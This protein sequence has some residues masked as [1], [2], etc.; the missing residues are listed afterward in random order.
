MLALL[1]ALLPLPGLAGDAAP[2]PAL[3]VR[4]NAVTVSGISSG[5]Y[6]A[7]QYHFAHSASVA[8]VGVLAAGPYDCAAGSIWA[9]LTRCMEPRFWSPLPD[10]ETLNRRAERSARDGLI[11]SLAGLD[12]DRAWI[13]SGGQDETVERPVVEALVAQYRSRLAA[14]DVRFVTLQAAGHAM[15]SVEEPQAGPCGS[16]EPPYINRCGTLDAAG[17]LLNHLLGPLNPPS[18]PPPER[19]RAFDQRPFLGA[20]PLSSGMADIGYLF[21]PTACESG[22]CRVHVAFHGCR[23]TTEQIGERFVRN[24]G[25]IEWAQSNEL[26]VLFPQVRPANGWLGGF[27]W[28]F[29]PRGCWDWWGYTDG[30]YAQRQGRQVSAVHAMLQRLGGAAAG[31]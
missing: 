28:Q 15:I 17:E 12:G 19:V 13:F 31:P 25:Y 20:D 11:D 7:V 14:A 8:G 2:L 23:Q 9:A 22:G 30:R 27:S 3:A 18:E 16:S 29:N 1:L 24:A 26:V 4:T 5:G 10:T 6:M 21:V